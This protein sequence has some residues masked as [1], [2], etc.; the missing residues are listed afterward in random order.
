MESENYYKTPQATVTNSVAPRKAGWLLI[1]FAINLTLADLFLSYT[2]GLL[3]FMMG[4]QLLGFALG[5]VIFGGLITLLFMLGKRFRNTRSKLK[6]YN[7]SMFF[8]LFSLL[9]QLGSALR[10]S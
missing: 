10:V 5:P 2:V 8:F 1:L 9:S 7:W 4:A 6:I 3:K